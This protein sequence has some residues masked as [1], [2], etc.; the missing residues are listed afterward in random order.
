[1]TCN[2]SNCRRLPITPRILLL[3]KQF[4][5]ADPGNADSKM[6]WAATCLC[7]FGFLRSGEV[8][9]PS[10]SQFDPDELVF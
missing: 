4:W 8:L 2:P 7:F 6:L 5:A 10:E 9:A 1:M 3:M